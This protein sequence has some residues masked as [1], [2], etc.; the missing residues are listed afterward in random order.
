MSGNVPHGQGPYAHN[1][2]DAQVEEKI[3]GKIEEKM[4]KGLDE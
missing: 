2:F 4:G 1:S 3:E